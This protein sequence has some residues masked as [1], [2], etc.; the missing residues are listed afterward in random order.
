MIAR[1]TVASSMLLMASLLA[2]ANAE[3]TTGVNLCAAHTIVVPMIEDGNNNCE[4]E[5]RTLVCAFDTICNKSNEKECAKL[6]MLIDFTQSGEETITYTADYG[7]EGVKVKVSL[8]V[9]PTLEGGIS[10]CSAAAADDST[11]TCTICADGGGV[12][13]N[14]EANQPSVSTRTTKGCS[15]VDV[16]KFE[17]FVPF[18]ETTSGTTIGSGSAIEGVSGGD[19]SSESGSGSDGVVALASSEAKENSAATMA[20]SFRAALAVVASLAVAMSF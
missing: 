9:S 14:C 8:G 17:R 15:L 16:S 6:D 5:G 3:A 18:F 1:T 10:S 13:I 20:G 19:A 11:C 2:S 7:D 12:D 4:C